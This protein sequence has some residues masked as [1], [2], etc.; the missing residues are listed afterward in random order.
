MDMLVWMGV[1]LQGYFRPLIFI[2]TKAT[3]TNT[4]S[5]AKIPIPIPALNMP[6][7]TEQLVNERAKAESSAVPKNLFFIY[8]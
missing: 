7:T 2:I 3:T 1:I 5:T 6:V 8:T 4:A